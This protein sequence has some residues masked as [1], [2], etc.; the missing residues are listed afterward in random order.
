MRGSAT[1]LADFDAAIPHEQ[2]L[3]IIGGSPE[4]GQ[5]HLDEVRKTAL[6]MAKAYDGD[7]TDQA[8]VPIFSAAAN[9]VL[10]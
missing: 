5:E 6:A 2:Q 8:F 4:F 7:L 9:A 3:T 1:T 10:S